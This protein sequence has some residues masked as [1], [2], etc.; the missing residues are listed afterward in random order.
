MLQ[1]FDVKISLRFVHQ[2]F[3][4]LRYLPSHS[5]QIL[6]PGSRRR[7]VRQIRPALLAID[8]FVILQF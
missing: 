7:G 2:K 6:R 3:I 8:F 4:F 1:L 5:S